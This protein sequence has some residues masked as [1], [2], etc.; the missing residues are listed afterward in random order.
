MSESGE[1]IRT[2]R[3]GS[4]NALVVMPAQ[5]RDYPDSVIRRSGDVEA[6][7]TCQHCG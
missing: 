7:R 5:C 4:A 2:R 6:E 1:V 3:D